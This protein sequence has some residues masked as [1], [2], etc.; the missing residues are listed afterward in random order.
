MERNSWNAID[1][2]PLI[3]GVPPIDGISLMDGI[4]LLDPIPIDRGIIC[5]HLLRGGLVIACSREGLLMFA[6]GKVC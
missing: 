2:A 6:Q 5:W 3:D 1:G 4:P